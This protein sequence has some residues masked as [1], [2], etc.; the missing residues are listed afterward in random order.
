[1]VAMKK[2]ID[3]LAIVLPALIILLG[4]TRLFVKKTRGVNGL[5]M[6]FAILLLILGLLRYYVFPENNSHAPS[7]KLT[8]VKV[9]KHSEAFNISMEKML[10]D[11][12][13]LTTSFGQG[14]TS[15]IREKARGLQLSVDSFR[16]RELEVDTLIYQTALQPFENMKAELAS[17]LADPSMEEKRG[18]L[19]VL[20][21]EFYSLLNTVR[22]DLA[23]LYWL[24]CPNAFGEDRPGNWISK[25]EQSGN[26]YGEPGCGEIRTTI[27]FVPADTTANPSTGSGL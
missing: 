13:A 21:S 12:I 2:V 5:I 26:P 24:E 17:I 15:T 6:L 18:S 19:N 1:M 8:P 20:S 4:I 7:A 9:S 22:Y 16:I 14:D 11:Y 3:I 25:T 27:N 23:K 10:D